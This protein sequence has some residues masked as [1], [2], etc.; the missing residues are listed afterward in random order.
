MKKVIRSGSSVCLPL[1]LIRSAYYLVFLPC[2]I[3]VAAITLIV[4]YGAPFRHQLYPSDY[5]LLTM[6]WVF[7]IFPLGFRYVSIKLRH[8]K[9]VRIVDFL[10]SDRRFSPNANHEVFSAAKGKYLGID[11]RRGTI[12]Y[13]HMLRKGVIDVVGMT[14]SSWTNTELEGS[15]IRI[16]T[17]D[18]ELPMVS[19]TAPPAVASN[20]YDTLGAMRHQSYSEPC[21]DEPWTLHVARQSKF[22][23]FEHEVVV[24]QVTA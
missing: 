21:P 6:L 17:S 20:L 5:F 7:I 16:Y 4:F 18:P 13:V 2:A 11:I 15:A 24:P 10:K 8:K 23:E 9:L 19:I 1:A 22:I 14:M 3:L 12:L